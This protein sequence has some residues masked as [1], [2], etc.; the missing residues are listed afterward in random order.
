MKIKVRANIYS[1]H[2]NLATVLFIALI[3]M[4]TKFAAQAAGDKTEVANADVIK[5]ILAGEAVF[6]N[7]SWKLHVQHDQLDRD[8]LAIFQSGAS[9]NFERCAA[10]FYLGEA[11]ASN[12]VDALASN[13]TLRLKRPAFRLSV[14]MKPPALEALLKIGCPS[15][16]ALI[17]NLTDS[18]ESEVR[19]LSLKAL[20]Q[21]EGDKEIVEVR[22]KK[23]VNAQTDSQKQ[24]RLQEALKDLPAIRM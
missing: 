14:L 22:L 20:C 1:R 4:A 16:P 13:I 18:D 15:I 5:S 8:L 7:T 9:S 2:F 10:A 19:G 23:A 17:R 21:I 12:A 3:I 11:R 6:E 24:Q